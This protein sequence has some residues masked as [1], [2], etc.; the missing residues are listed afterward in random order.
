MAASVKERIC[1]KT[2][3]L[4]APSAQ[5][6]KAGECGVQKCILNHPRKSNAWPFTPACVM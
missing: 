5:E 1:S 4:A 6:G 3:I 2:V